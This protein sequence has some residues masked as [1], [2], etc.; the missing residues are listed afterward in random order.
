M[1]VQVTEID[2]E[3]VK[4]SRADDGKLCVSLKMGP[5]GVWLDVIKAPESIAD[6]IEVSACKIEDI[7]IGLDG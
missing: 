1:S 2:I 5:A 6:P 4:L 7:A 3:A